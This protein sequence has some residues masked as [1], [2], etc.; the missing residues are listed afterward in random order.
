MRSPFPNPLCIALDLDDPERARELA[1]RLHGVAG[2]VKIGLELFTRGGPGVV[3]AIRAEGPRIFL[4]LKLHDIPN[5]V[6]GAVR[7]IS[8]LPVHLT[9]LHAAGGRAMLEAAVEAR[10]RTRP[11]LKLVAVTVL[12][13][14]GL[15]ALRDL[16]IPQ[17][18]EERVLHLARLALEA[19]VDGLVCSPQEVGVLREALGPEPLLVVPGIRPEPAADDQV[20]T[21]TP[22]EA[23]AAG[24]DV[25]VVGRPVT[26]TPD[27]RAAAA[28]ILER[29]RRHHAG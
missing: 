4:D 21:A 17:E 7:A 9:T 29:L 20:R 5:T 16:G 13:S 14:L 10:N 24:A 23:L 11:T 19:G 6:A 27:P 1:A 26:R 25:L 22:E 28:A 8:D 12:T 3:R 18:P 2:G 15:A